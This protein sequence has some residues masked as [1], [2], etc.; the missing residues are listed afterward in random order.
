MDNH[1]L[2]V[3]EYVEVLTHLASCAQSEPGKNLALSLLP[4]SEDAEV[5]M[6]C[7]LTAEALKLFQD[8]PPDLGS[9]SDISALTGRLRVEGRQ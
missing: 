2:T 9:V 6:Q 7:D 1:T 3:L 8:S 4:C 5:R